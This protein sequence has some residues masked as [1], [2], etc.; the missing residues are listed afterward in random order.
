MDVLKQLFET[1][2]HFSPQTVNDLAQQFGGSLYWILFAIIFAETG[3]V[4]IPF[5]PGD[6]LLFAVGAVAA[7]PGSPIGIRLV[8]FLLV[9]AAILGDAVNYA[10]GY[11]VGPAV[12]ASD[13]SRFLNK[14]HLNKA[15]EFYETYGGKTIILARF[16][17]VIR[18]FA[19]FVAG[20][21]RMTYVKFAL[22]N[23]VG[24]IAWVL[25][26][27]SAGWFFG[28]YEFVQKRFELVILA[29]VFISILPA[30]VEILR[31]R[32]RAVE[33]DIA[34]TRSEGAEEERAV[35]H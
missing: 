29:I 15:H 12:F 26:C 18:T 31:A 27:L 16:I 30:A 17:P 13:R 21:G 11:Y 9:I 4:L 24:G 10:V 5:L 20:V 14:K 23:V 25:I 7:H 1:I 35:A 32:F 6:S 3:L 8:G 22:Y 33:P 28:G 34:T 2:R 19:P